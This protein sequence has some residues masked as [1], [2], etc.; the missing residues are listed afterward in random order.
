MKSLSLAASVMAM[1]HSALGDEMRASDAA[2]IDLF[3]WDIMDGHFVPNMTFGAAALRDLRSVTNKEFDTHLMVTNPAQWI[4][5]FAKAGSN[6]ITF[7]AELDDLDIIALAQKIRAHGIQAGLAFNPDTPLDHVPQDVFA[8]IDRILIMTVF[9]GFGGQA[10]IDQSAKIQQAVLLKQR[11]PHLC[12]AVDGGINL[13]TAPIAIKAGAD[14]LVSGSAL[15]KASSQADFITA[16]KQ[17][18]IAA[19]A[20]A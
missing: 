4:D 1:N 2:G 14:L 13:D 5:D 11:F 17:Q 12:I 18:A 8:H 10:F 19:G 3:H 20:L 7:H 9:P 15:N 16:I 6:A